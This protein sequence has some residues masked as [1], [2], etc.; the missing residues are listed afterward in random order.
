[1]QEETT[2]KQVQAQSTKRE[3][4]KPLMGQLKVNLKLLMAQERM[5]ISVRKARKKVLGQTGSVAQRGKAAQ[6]RAIKQS[7]TK[8][9]Q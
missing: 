1:M 3:I 4:V 2:Y 5:K 7:R 6:T 8:D 9:V